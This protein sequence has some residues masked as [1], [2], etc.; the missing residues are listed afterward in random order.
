MALTLILEDGTGVTNAN[1]YVTLQEV[2]TYAETILGSTWDQNCSLQLL[3][4]VNAS[5]FIDQKYGARYKGV[6]LT[7]TQGLLYPRTQLCG[8]STVGVPKGLKN[9]VAQAALQFI[10]DGSLDLN[11]N[12]DNAIKSKAVGIGGGAVTESISYFFPQTINV[13]AVVDSYMAPLLGKTVSS[14]FNNPTV[15]G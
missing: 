13:Y 1:S 10:E 4:V 15:R 11:A 2:S 5:R 9:A 3:A 6:P 12:Q 7:E 14:G 8:T